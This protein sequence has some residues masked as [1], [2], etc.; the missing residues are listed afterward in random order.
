MPSAE[1]IAI[2]TELLLGEIQDTNTFYLARALRDAGVNL[3]RTM[4]VGDNPARIAK[5]IQESLER[6]DIVI[7]TGGLGPTI[8]DPTRQA[9]AD[10]MGVP[11]EFRPDLWEMIKTRYL[12]YGRPPSENN[13]RQAYVPKGA[14]QIENPVGTAPGFIVETGHQSVIS[15][16]GV[17]REMEY[18]IERAVIPYLRNRFQL[19]G[20]IK[21]YVLHTAGIGESQID[22]LIGDLETL[23]NPTVGL[24][25]HAGQADIRVTAR[26]DSALEA[27]RLIASTAE[28]IRQRLG[29]HIYGANGQ[30]LEAILQSLLQARGWKVAA[31]EGGL[32]N[33]LLQRL[34]TL[35]PGFAG[36]EFIPNPLERAA[37]AVITSQ[38][39]QERQ[40]EIGLGASLQ[41]EE[42]QQVLDIVVVTSQS[43]EA[44]TRYYGGPPQIG[45]RWATNTALDWLR[46]TLINTK[47]QLGA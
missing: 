10:A 17:P 12:R 3:Y 5:A 15:V 4:M 22:E 18:L 29:V 26:A 43:Q 35:G 20:V 34:S 32:G 44:V 16:P 1:I 7:T 24:L 23:T 8:D 33:S 13:K 37:L 36:G 38:T 21:A 39:L 2:G 27:D 41:V 40:A 6:A 30:T 45:N 47:N 42:D 14:I 11:L 25:A 31:V 46:R 28:E 19:R 9:V